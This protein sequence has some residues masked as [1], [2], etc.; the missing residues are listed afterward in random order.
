MRWR[1]IAVQT[2]ITE[3]KLAEHAYCLVHS[4]ARL[5]LALN[6]SGIGIWQYDP[7]TDELIWDERMYDI[8]GVDPGDGAVTRQLW[9]DSL[10]PEDR[11]DIEALNQ[12]AIQSGET[13]ELRYRIITPDDEVRHII[14]LMRIVMDGSRPKRS[15]RHQSRC[16]QR[17]CRGR[18]A[19]DRKGNIARDAAF[20]PRRRRCDGRQGQD[21]L[22]Q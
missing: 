21:H 16:D 6:A 9:A 17:G 22:R 13:M 10:H 19:C 14:A 7:E 3:Q 18:S 8:F 12:A 4:N 1:M 15:D 5:R 20:D 11:V 2:D